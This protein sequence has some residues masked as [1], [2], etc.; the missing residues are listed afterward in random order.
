M[1]ICDRCRQAFPDGDGLHYKGDRYCCD[2]AEIVAFW[3]TIEH[4]DESE[5]TA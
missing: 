5:A 2:C 1:T 3:E 4:E